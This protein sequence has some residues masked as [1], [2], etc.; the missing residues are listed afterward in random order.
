MVD[1]SG[2]RRYKFCAA[3]FV[4][5]FELLFI[6][7]ILALFVGYYWNISTDQSQYRSAGFCLPIAGSVVSVLIILIMIIGMFAGKPLL[8]IPHLVAQIL[9]IVIMTTFVAFTFLLIFV[10]KT[11]FKTFYIGEDFVSVYITMAALCGLMTLAEIWFFFVVKNCYDTIKSEKVVGRER[12][13]IDEA[14]KTY[15]RNY[16]NYWINNMISIE[17]PTKNVEKLKIEDVKVETS[18]KNNSVKISK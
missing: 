1:C 4:A 6:A 2:K 8:I 10:G 7:V 14:N 15:W 9:A 17:S 12:K 11:N 16:W 13:Q 5:V 3:L 18:S